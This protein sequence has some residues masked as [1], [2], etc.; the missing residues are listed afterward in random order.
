MAELTFQ[1][2]DNGLYRV[3]YINGEWVTFEDVTLEDAIKG[4]LDLLYEKSF[5][6][7]SIAELVFSA[8]R[9]DLSCH[10]NIPMISS[11]RIPLNLH[12]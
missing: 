3:D 8:K 5:I 6:P 2:Q 10:H 11:S 4:D 1:K 12:S 7:A 9:R